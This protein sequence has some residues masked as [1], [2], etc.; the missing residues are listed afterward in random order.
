MN[1]IGGK[2]RVGANGVVV[3]VFDV[4]KVNVP[5]ILAFVTDHG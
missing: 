2:A 5:V 1:F 4:G 3:G